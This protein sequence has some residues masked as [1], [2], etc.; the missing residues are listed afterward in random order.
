M[1]APGSWSKWAV[2]WLHEWDEAVAI[3]RAVMCRDGIP[4]MLAD[5]IEEHREAVERRYPGM[6]FGSVDAVLL[7]LRRAD[8]PQVATA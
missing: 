8:S 7:H 2:V 3:L 1:T 5:W 6:P 4:G